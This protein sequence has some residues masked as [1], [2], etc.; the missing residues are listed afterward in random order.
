M[1]MSVFYLP[2]Y[3]GTL[4][5]TWSFSTLPGLNLTRYFSYLII[6]YLWGSCPAPRYLCPERNFE[7][8]YVRYVFRAGM[9]DS[10]L[11]P[12]VS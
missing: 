10:T 4:N 2:R 8:L 5:W 1:T 12:R 11:G 7:V 6:L 3:A 9:S